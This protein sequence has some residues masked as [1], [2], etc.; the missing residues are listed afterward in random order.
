MPAAWEDLTLAELA[1]QV[2][3]YTID[4]LQAF[5]DNGVLPDMVQIG[6]EII[7]G[8]LWSLGRTY[9]ADNNDIANW[10]AFGTLMNAGISAARTFGVKVMVH[11][12]SGGDNEDPPKIWLDKL[13]TLAGVTDFDVFGVSYYSEWHGTP[14][15]LQTNLTDVANNYDYDIVI[16]EYSAEKDAVH[17]IIFNLPGDKGIGAFIWEP[18]KWDESLFGWKKRFNGFVTNSLIDLYPGYAAAYGVPER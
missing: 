9:D 10:E 12:L 11:T 1:D 13:T 16:A 5:Q 18:T 3:D 14:E 7:H 8:M 2:Y 15:V 6:N 17:E 4:T